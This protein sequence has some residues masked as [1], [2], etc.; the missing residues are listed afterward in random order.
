MIFVQ[1]IFPAGNYCSM[2]QFAAAL[3]NFVILG[4]WQFCTLVVVR[5]LPKLKR[6][7]N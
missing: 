1:R 7:D 4:T 2:L 6:I 3:I 5:F